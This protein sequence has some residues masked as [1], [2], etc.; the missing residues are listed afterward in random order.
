MKAVLDAVILIDYLNGIVASKKELD[1]YK[2][3]Q[4]SIIS[5]M[6][7]LVGAKG[8]VD[9]AKIRGFLASFETIDVSPEV[10]KEAISIRRDLRLKVPDAIVYGTAR[11]Q[12]CILVTRNS[13][14]FNEE[15]PDIRIPYRL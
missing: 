6:E 11:T 9:E 13:K 5:F 7:V 2:V 4:I 3:R 8:L 15:W 10:A 12:G 1:Q 14:D